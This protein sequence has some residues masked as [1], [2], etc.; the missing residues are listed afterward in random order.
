M[1]FSPPKHFS[2]ISVLKAPF[3][4]V[5]IFQRYKTAPPN[6]RLDPLARNPSSV[7]SLHPTKIRQ[8][9]DVQNLISELSLIAFF[10]LG[11]RGRE[12]DPANGRTH[13]YLP[14]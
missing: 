2:N 12:G 11:L 5:S 7:I 10:T 14:G 13:Q 6:L 9:E 8:S 1:S 3:D 4:N